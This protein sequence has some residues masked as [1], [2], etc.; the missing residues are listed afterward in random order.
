MLDGVPETARRQSFD[1]D[2]GG[3]PDS[4]LGGRPD[5]YIDEAHRERRD[6]GIS[7]SLPEFQL[8]DEHSTPDWDVPDTPRPGSAFFL[9]T[10]RAR[11][12]SLSPIRD[13]KYDDEEE[14]EDMKQRSSKRDTLMSI[15]SLA[16]LDISSFPRP[17]SLIPPTP[18]RLVSAAS[19]LNLIPPPTPL[20]PISMSDSMSSTSSSNEGMEGYMGEAEYA[21]M[22]DREHRLHGDG[23]KEK[24]ITI[25][26]TLEYPT[27]LTIVLR[28]GSQSSYE[29]VR[30][31]MK[32]KVD[33]LLNGE[34][35]FQSS[36]PTSPA[37]SSFSHTSSATTP[38]K[39]KLGADFGITFN[40]RMVASDKDWKVLVAGNNEKVVLKI[41][42]TLS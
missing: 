35:A 42:D 21:A 33:L 34:P 3:R 2:M 31:K 38:P 5:S 9:N 16:S 13:T 30:R 29:D 15:S 18:I 22:L 25:K 17:P 28:V 14:Y 1:L 4:Y 32:Q 23:E 19:N 26:A 37:S 41:L 36:P 40:G 27:M 6:S 39:H 10:T 20:S 7:L 12:Q 24:M 11:A 8:S